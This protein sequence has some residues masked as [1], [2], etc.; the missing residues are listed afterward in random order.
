M[1]RRESLL[2]KTSSLSSQAKTDNASEISMDF[3]SGEIC[4]QTQEDRGSR[5]DVILLGDKSH[6]LSSMD[7]VKKLIGLP[8][9]RSDRILEADLGLMFYEGNERK[10][11]SFGTAVF[12]EDDITEGK[13][14]GLTMDEFAQTRRCTVSNPIWAD[15]IAQQLNKA[16]K[17]QS[18]IVFC[19]ADHLRVNLPGERCDSLQ[20][21]L[22]KRKV[23]CIAYT[24]NNDHE[25][26]F[27]VEAGGAI[28][29]YNFAIDD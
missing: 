20:Q 25:Q 28:T 18:H 5:V 12:L 29:L 8:A 11:P 17:N 23:K 7:N 24:F 16:A 14:S 9:E 10:G 1:S 6:G 3:L 4:E 26:M 19:G 27:E 2:S 15:K 21:E 22:Q 13:T